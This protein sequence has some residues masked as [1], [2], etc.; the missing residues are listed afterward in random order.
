MPPRHWSK[1]G[2]LFIQFKIFLK[3]CRWLVCYKSLSLCH[4]GVVRWRSWPGTLWCLQSSLDICWTDCRYV[5]PSWAPAGSQPDR[6]LSGILRSGGREVHCR[7]MSS[8]RRQSSLG[9]SCCTQW[10]PSPGLER[11]SN[12]K[13]EGGFSSTERRAACNRMNIKDP[14]SA[15]KREVIP[16]DRLKC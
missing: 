9:L 10:Q 4:G 3:M 5:S 2:Q 12:R 13:V 14:G 1:A 8:D 7:E 16:G 11:A 15:E 6:F